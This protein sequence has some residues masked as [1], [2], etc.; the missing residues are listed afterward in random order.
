MKNENNQNKSLYWY[1]F[2]AKL[3]VIGGKL[4]IGLG[5][6]LGIIFMFSSLWMGII[7]LLIFL[8]IGIYLI[9]TGNAQRFDFERQSGTILHQGDWRR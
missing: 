6:I 8:V 1:G 3:K 9:A 4:M 2:F 7:I 5:I